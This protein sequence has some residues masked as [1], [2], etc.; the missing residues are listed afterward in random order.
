M[1]YGSY[2]GVP[3]WLHFCEGYALHFQTMQGFLDGFLQPLVCGLCEEFLQEQGT[4]SQGD[5]CQGFHKGECLT[6][7][8][9]RTDS[10]QHCQG[11][12]S[13]L[14]TQFAGHIEPQVEWELR[15]FLRPG[16]GRRIVLIQRRGVSD[17][18]LVEQACR[19]HQPVPVG[20]VN[21]S[22]R[23]FLHLYGPSPRG[24]WQGCAATPLL[25]QGCQI[26]RW[27]RF[28]ERQDHLLLRC[29]EAS[30]AMLQEFA[31]LWVLL[32]QAVERGP[33]LIWR[34]AEVDASFCQGAD[35]S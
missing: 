6:P 11:Q 2:H 17:A 9:S 33:G 32:T 27:R 26:R 31:Q 35:T 23:M 14:H 1:R 16:G 10:V 30:K 15:Q 34:A 13:V 28:Q 20:W 25:Q 12:V 5:V 21:R 22:I 8:G 24:Q 18:Q 4:A 19:L 3:L 29:G 7:T